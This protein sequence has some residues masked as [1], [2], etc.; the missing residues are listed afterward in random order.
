MLEVTKTIDKRVLPAFY[1]A[2]GRGRV[3]LFIDEHKGIIVGGM[4][5]RVGLGLGDLCTSY[6]S[7]MDRDVWERVEV[8]IDS[9]DENT[10]VIQFPVLREK[11]DGQVVL[12]FDDDF[13]VELLLVHI[14]EVLRGR[15]KQFEVGAYKAWADTNN[16]ATWRYVE[17]TLS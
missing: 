10:D 16:T 11:L 6:I 9:A 8:R 15:E 2:R 4:D 3:V 17:A 1:R 7:C 5:V 12:F 13:G 14:L